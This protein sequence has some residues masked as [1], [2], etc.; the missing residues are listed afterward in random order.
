MALGRPL[1]TLILLALA[2]SLGACAVSPVLP[3][4]GTLKGEQVWRGRVLVDGDVVIEEGARLTILPGTEVLFM[5][6]SAGE[7]RLTE[8]PHFAGSELIVRGAIFAEGTPAAPIVFRHADPAAPAGSWGGVNLA[9]SP[10]ASFRF[11]R[12]TQAD[13]ALHSQ[14]SRVLVEESLFERNLVG[15]R[16]HS[17]D[18][19]IRRNLLRRNDTAIRFHY[20]APLVTGNDIRENDR[21]F[22]ITAFPRDYRIEGNRIAGNREAN[23]VLGEEVPEDVAMARNWWGATEPADLEASFFDGRRVGYLGRVIYEPPAQGAPREVGIS[24]KP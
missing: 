3:V 13:S 2:L 8:H 22:F 17:S 12:F 10:G 15:I 11:C 1:S 14:A 21:G 20:G 4:A 19:V 18:I 6:P 7:D 9:E 5:P 23:V 24:W 16:F